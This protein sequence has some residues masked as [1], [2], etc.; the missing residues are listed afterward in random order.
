MMAQKL[1]KNFRMDLLKLN[2]LS[3]T[4]DGGR[5]SMSQPEPG[6]LHTP[7]SSEDSSPSVNTVQAFCYS[8]PTHADA[9]LLGSQY[10]GTQGSSQ[11]PHTKS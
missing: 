1:F 3:R 7:T 6:H 5:V 9:M 8:Q 4:E 10:Q 2:F 11:V